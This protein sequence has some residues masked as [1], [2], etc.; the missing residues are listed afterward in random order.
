M[1]RE[2]YNI[3]MKKEL[4][5]LLERSID[6]EMTVSDLYGLY[7]QLF[8]E[9][10][11]FWWVLCLEEKNHAALLKSARIYLNIDRLPQEALINDFN[12]LDKSVSAVSAKLE[13]YRNNPPTMNDAYAFARFVE[14]SAA[15]IHMQKVVSSQSDDRILK[16]FHEL[17]RGDA[18]HSERING[19]IQKRGINA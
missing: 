19:L 14:D 17:G 12:V 5:D 9:D 1:P 15:E 18:N 3:Y 11:D 2:P 13:E 16:I 6:M 4:S 10:R 8:D 7:S